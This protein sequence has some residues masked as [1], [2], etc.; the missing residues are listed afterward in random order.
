[1]L[2]THIVILLHFCCYDERQLDWVRDEGLC[3]G[4]TGKVKAKFS[5]IA[6][7][8]LALLAIVCLFLG[9]ISLGIFLSSRAAASSRYPS[10]LLYLQLVWGL[11]GLTAFPLGLAGGI[12]A[13]KRTRLELAVVG[14]LAILVWSL[15]AAVHVTLMNQRWGPYDDITGFI[16]VFSL[17]F[18]AILCLVMTA[19]SER[20]F[21][22]ST[23]YR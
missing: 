3:M 10:D 9:A 18:S 8:I 19:V 13:L 23:N 15:L 7:I 6:G 12:A 1:M 11:V 20:E 5:A 16:F 22:A 2:V 21:A 17:A 4:Y 14:S